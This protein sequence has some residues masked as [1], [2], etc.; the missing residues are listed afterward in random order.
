LDQ[1]VSGSYTPPHLGSGLYVVQLKANGLNRFRQVF[2]DGKQMSLSTD[3]GIV[4]PAVGE[5]AKAAANGD[6]LVFIKSGYREKELAVA[7]GDTNL[8]VKLV[9][10]E[11]TH[12]EQLT[13]DDVGPWSLQGV[14]RGSEVLSTLDPG[15]ERLSNWPNWG[16]PSWI[17]GTPYVYNNDPSNHGG[18][19]PEG[20]L[21]ID[22]YNVPAGTWVCQFRDF[23]DGVIIEGDNDGQQ[24][25]WP[26]VLFRGCRMRGN[27]SAP[28]WF[29][30]NSVSNGGIIWIM[31]CDAGGIAYLPPNICV[32]IF[33]SQRNGGDDKF[34][35]IRNYLSIATTLAFGRN[36][37]D[38]F[39]ENYCRS[40][41][42]YYPDDTYHL[43]GIANGGGETATMWL[44]N[45][46]DFDPQPGAP[47]NPYYL[48]QN[49][50][51]QMAADGGA[52]PGTGTNLDGSQGYQIRDNYL[53]GAAHTLQLGV[54]KSNSSADVSNVVITGNRFSTKWFP[55]CGS[56]AISYKNPTWGVQGNTWSTNT[57]ADDYGSGTGQTGRQYPNGDGPR[58][59]QPV[60]AP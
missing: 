60:A 35:C 51:I 45:N 38:A 42:R 54:D 12:G 52:Y 58:A 7:E 57:W 2:I 26:G 53:A 33:E 55:D 40:V 6:T 17:P 20:G 30:C 41:C 18:V 29:N 28:G 32:S 21:T 10:L 47:D 49:D 44:R 43:N 24:A 8:V 37:G 13:I 11:I 15:G 16:R 59:G 14:E 36:D 23:T 39:I 50:V 25:A 22:G 3:D 1:S 31:Y 46:M 9:A 34:Y 19:V 27:W 48:P 56:T 5:L 4:A